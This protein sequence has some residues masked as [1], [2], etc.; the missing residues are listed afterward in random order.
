[1]TPDQIHQV[2]QALEFYADVANYQGPS[3]VEACTAV[4]CDGGKRAVAAL[5]L[6]TL[7]LNAPGSEEVEAIRERHK[8][9]EEL[10]IAWGGTPAGHAAHNDRATLLRLLDAERAELDKEQVSH[11]KTRA[12]LTEIRGA[13]DAERARRV[14]E[15]WQD[16]STAPKSGPPIELY[17]PEVATPVR[18]PAQIWL[19]NRWDIVARDPIAWRHHTPPTL[20]EKAL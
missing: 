1:M 9:D 18:L 14:S 6:L 12:K 20:Q 7:S 13:L 2:R 15:G 11:L 5:S 8:S 4:W 17:F 3:I 19:G 10:E 16:I